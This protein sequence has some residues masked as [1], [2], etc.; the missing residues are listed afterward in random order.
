MRRLLK[1]KV[2]FLLFLSP[3][4][5]ANDALDFQSKA[6]NAAAKMLLNIENQY[7]YAKQKNINWTCLKTHYI[8][9]IKPIENRSDAVLHFEHLLMEFAD[10]HMTLNTN[11]HDSYRLNAPLTVKKIDQS[12]IINDFW[13]SQ[14]VNPQALTIGAELVSINGIKPQEAIDAFPTKC[15]DKAP[16]RNQQWIINKTLAGQY[17]KPRIIEF[18][19]DN[20]L[21]QV[22]LDLL[23]YKK[24]RQ[25]LV[26]SVKNQL[27]IITINN[28]L[29]KTQ[30]IHSFDQA[31]DQL[32]QTRGLVLDLRNTINGGDSYIARA[33]IGRFIDQ[34]SAYQ[35]HRFEEQNDGGPKVTR[36]WTEYAAPRGSVYKRPLVVLVNRWTGSMGEGLAIGLHGMQRGR[37][38]GTPMAG[39]LGAVYSFQ[40]E[41][42]GFGYQLPAEQLFHIDGTPRELFLPDTIVKPDQDNGDRVLDQAT[43]WLLR[44]NKY[45][46]S[47]QN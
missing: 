32:S 10:N 37:V 30:L 8:N 42:M 19:V 4:I 16:D 34:E 36:L 44:N 31:I 35:K 27:G 46:L 22:D 41:G 6:E 9:N 24:S 26:T 12:F 7:A 39:L 45:N 11:I 47:T 38:I 14:L 28:S 43:Q 21:I 3:S 33:I 23:S 13:Q 20:K 15:L 1:A 17:S 5:K 40:I 25:P 18:S 29:G 2:M